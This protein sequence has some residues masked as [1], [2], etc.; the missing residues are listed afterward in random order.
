[1]VVRLFIIKITNGINY[2]RDDLNFFYKL[3]NLKVMI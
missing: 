3:I 2:F 1:M